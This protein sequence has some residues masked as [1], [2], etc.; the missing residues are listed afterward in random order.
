[1]AA[2]QLVPFQSATPF[3]DPELLA[4]A[5]RSRH[6]STGNA[7]GECSRWR[8][9][10]VAPEAWPPLIVGD[11]GD[12]ALVASAEWFG[13]GGESYRIVIMRSELALVLANAAPR[14]FVAERVRLAG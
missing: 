13:D 7:C 14:D 2:E 6:G 5:A 4:T 10:P 8:W 12:H 9:L 3:F 1:M 11:W